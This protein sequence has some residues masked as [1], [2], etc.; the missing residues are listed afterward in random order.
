MKQSRRHNLDISQQ[1]TPHTPRIYLLARTNDIHLPSVLHLHIIL[2]VSGT[3]RRFRI[4]I[5]KA[6]RQRWEHGEMCGIEAKA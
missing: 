4:R 2:L 1:P 5:E 6:H 3:T